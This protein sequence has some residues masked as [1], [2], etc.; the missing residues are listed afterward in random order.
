M[1]N[2]LTLS[3]LIAACAWR[4]VTVDARPPASAACTDYPLIAEANLT[5][6]L[7]RLLQEAGLKK[8]GDSV[9]QDDGSSVSIHVEP[10]ADKISAFE[11]ISVFNGATEFR[12]ERALYCEAYDAHRNS[13]IRVAK[14]EQPV[15]VWMIHG[16]EDGCYIRRIL[17]RD[18]ALVVQDSYRCQGGSKGCARGDSNIVE[19]ATATL[20]ASNRDEKIKLAIKELFKDEKTIMLHNNA[21]EDHVFGRI[22]GSFENE[23]VINWQVQAGVFQ[24]CVNLRVPTDD[25]NAQKWAEIEQRVI[26]RKISDRLGGLT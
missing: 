8:L 23:I 6:D 2:I 15:V 7:D 17:E 16:I 26:L 10:L 11:A 3:F 9:I 18:G 25:E 4:N 19:G 1:R 24:V 12:L 22:D 13:G 20:E 21:S 14:P 5:S